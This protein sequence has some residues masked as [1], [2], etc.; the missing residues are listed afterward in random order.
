[1]ENC[2]EEK[3]LVFLSRPNP[4]LEKHVI[5]I[6]KLQNVLGEHGIKTITLQANNYDLTDSLNYL[7]GMIKQCYGIVIIGFKQIF[8]ENGI[9]KK[10]A[11]NNPDFFNPEEE[12]YSGSAITSPFCH[13]EGTI[14]LLNDLPL[15]II[16]EEGVKEEGI[17][18][19][20]KYCVKTKKFDI[21]NIEKFW[22]DK[23]VLQQISVWIGKVVEY[24][25]FLKLKKV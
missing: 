18:Q 17:I 20:G 13:I 5:F 7:K 2:N 6:E 16:N 3:I 24:Y 1:M 8:I 11:E 25:L 21:E 9:K 23:I 10:G 14:A 19:G 4:F 15:L 22:E 12:N